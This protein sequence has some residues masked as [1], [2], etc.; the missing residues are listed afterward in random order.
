MVNTLNSKER[1]EDNI[2]AISLI[3][4]KGLLLKFKTKLHASAQLHSDLWDNLLYKVPSL[5]KIQEKTT[6]ILVLDKEIE[7]KW[8]I[9]VSSGLGSASLAHLYSEYAHKVKGDHGY[10]NL[11]KYK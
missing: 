2:Q 6:Q 5:Q 11:L 3:K 1:G 7:K 4:S 8:D 9:F 10:S